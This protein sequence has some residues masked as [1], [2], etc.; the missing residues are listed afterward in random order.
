MTKSLN[1]S[2]T[3]FPD[4]CVF[5]ELAMQRTIDTGCETCGLYQLETDPA[6]ARF[7]ST[8]YLDIYCP[9]GHSSL[10]NLKK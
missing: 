7:S 3:F 4:Q 10:E 1:C 5:K 8:S 2:I 9:L 6:V